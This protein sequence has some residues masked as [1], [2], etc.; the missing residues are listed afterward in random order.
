MMR[1]ILLLSMYIILPILYFTMANDTKPKKNII[2]GAT[3]PYASLKDPRVLKICTEFKKALKRSLLILAIVAL[4][5][6]VVPYISISMAI[7]FTW[8]IPA[9]VVPMVIYAK[10]RRRLITLKKE[11][12]NGNESLSSVTYVDLQASVQQTKPLSLW[13]H[14]P[15]LVAACI[16]VADCLLS[17]QAKS[18][19]WML[20]LYGTM[21]SLPVL[22]LLLHGVFQRQSPDVVGDD[23]NLN[24]AL[25]RIRRRRYMAFCLGFSWLS[26]FLC[27]IPWLMMKERLSYFW[28]M[29]FMILYTVVLM[30]VC[31]YTEFRT[32]HQTEQMAP[33]S[34]TD[35]VNDED[36]YWIAGQ[37]YYNPQDKHLMKASR[38]GVS[39]TVNMAHPVGK[40]LMVLSVLCLLSLPVCGLWMIGEEF[41]PLSSN[42]SFNLG[43]NIPF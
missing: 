14:M 40:I 31:F 27:L 9:I 28:G 7:L 10:Y 36:R 17:Y 32:R 11:M 29:V 16:P 13:W 6:L 15:P 3:L 19:G 25:T 26:G 23:S 18:D 1:I 41:V 30:V 33:G 35:M 22:A 5:C 39:S 4:P 34:P 12:L 38:I 21:A 8:V 24:A 43:V 42:A 37:F 2:L 20:F